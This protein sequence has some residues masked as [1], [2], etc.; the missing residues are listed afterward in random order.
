MPKRMRYC[1]IANKGRWLK[2]AKMK[3][4]LKD[5]PKVYRKIKH[6]RG[7]DEHEKVLYARSL[8][9]TPEERLEMNFNCLRLLGFS[10]PIR[11]RRELERRKAKLRKLDAFG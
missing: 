8:A 11:S 7:L 5:W 9:A 2:T 4:K 6:V 1:G 3:T 10:A